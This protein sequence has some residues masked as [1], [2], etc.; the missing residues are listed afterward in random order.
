[1]TIAINEKFSEPDVL[2]Y[3]WILLDEVRNSPEPPEGSDGGGFGAGVDDW[4]D[5]EPDIII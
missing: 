5:I 1:M 3:Q 4:E 2:D